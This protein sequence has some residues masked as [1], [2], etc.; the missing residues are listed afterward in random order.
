MGLCAMVLIWWGDYIHIKLEKFNVIG[1]SMPL[2][3][4]PEIGPSDMGIVSHRMRG[5]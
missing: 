1:T 2:L 4:A 3:E 5:L